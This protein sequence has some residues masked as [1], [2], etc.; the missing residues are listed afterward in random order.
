MS[1]YF[2]RVQRQTSA[3]FTCKLRES[4]PVESEAYESHLVLAEQSHAELD[5]SWV[6]TT[7]TQTSFDLHN[8]ITISVVRCLT[9]CWFLLG[10]QHT[11]I[12]DSTHLPVTD[13]ASFSL[14]NERRA[15]PAYFTSLFVFT[16]ASC[17]RQAEP[18]NSPSPEHMSTKD[19]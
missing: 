5:L 19:R 13:E 17:F 16:L 4:L 2:Q 3:L 11:V 15:C 18:L 9:A 1:Y 12:S 6:T 14:R 10:L 7:R 8:H